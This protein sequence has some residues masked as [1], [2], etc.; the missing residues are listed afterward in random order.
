MKRVLIGLIVVGVL[1]ASGLFEWAQSVLTGDAV[2]T[3][4]A[5]RLSD[6]LG[7]PVTIG[8]LT[9]SIFPR[10]SLNLKDVAIGRP[11]QLTAG[12]IG[13]GTDF[14]ALLSR[15]IEHATIRLDA[16]HIALPLFPLPASAPATSTS[17]SS[18]SGVT[19][20]S[21]DEIV[22]NDVTIASGSRMLH[23]DLDLAVTGATA[24]VRKIA[25]RADGT[26]VTLT[27]AFTDY[28]KPT[29]TL[30]AKA[31][32]LNVLDLVSFVTD[33]ANSAGLSSTAPQ[34]APS[35]TAAGMDVV[36]NVDADRATIG[37]LALDHVAGRAR[38]TDTAITIDP[39]SFDVFGGTY[40]GSLVLTLGATPAFRVNATLANVDMAAFM[41]FAHH[42]G[43]VTGRLAGTIAIAGRGLS[44][45]DV[46]NSS[47]GTA[48]ATIANGT[49][50]GLGLVKG[51]VLATSMRADSTPQATSTSASEP[52]TSLTGTFAI[53]NGAATS[54]DLR[55][56]SNDV[57]LAATGSV[58]LDGASVQLAGPLQL[59]DALSKQAGRDLVKYTQQ[60][61]RVTLPA[62]VSGSAD[63][64]HVGIDTGALAKRAI[65]NAA[66]DAAKK[67]LG[68]LG[69]GSGS[70]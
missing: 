8:S 54:D 39:A 30:T 44:A 10:L 16:A 21:V 19:L 43:L 70:H 66:T 29:G 41:T 58:R 26:T 3:S 42:P 17:A 68:R 69:G 45:A 56:T 62:T 6:S 31:G 2:R 34:A 59:S 15:R 23:A 38:I 46:V 20:V 47:R 51:V 60:N 55:F 22:L 7:Q 33:F 61:G 4:L 24:T 67:L 37:D 27:G 9:A 49:I 11:G 53:A 13:V 18:S 50:K 35:T 32:S 64:L 12:T 28:A 14:R 1:V 36:V 5:A 40:R 63:D 65:T 25:L 57:L 52:F 48:R